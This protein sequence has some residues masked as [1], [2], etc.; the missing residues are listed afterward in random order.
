MTTALLEKKLTEELR[1][2]APEDVDPFFAGLGL[3]RRPLFANVLRAPLAPWTPTIEMFVTKGAIVVRAELPGL[4]KEDVK[5]EIVKGALTIEGE[6]KYEKEIE[7]KGYFHDGVRY[8]NV[9]SPDPR[10]DRPR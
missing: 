5:V 4:T 8:R 2:E 1:K 7:E 10:F 3:R 6:R 9:L